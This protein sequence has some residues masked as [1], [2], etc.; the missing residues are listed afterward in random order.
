V[1]CAWFTPSRS[2]NATLGVGAAVLA[3]GLARYDM[4]ATNDGPHHLHAAVVAHR[5]V[6]RTSCSA[7]P[8]PCGTR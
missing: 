7:P 5:Y 3:L 4:V 2:R 6:G 8:S 1:F